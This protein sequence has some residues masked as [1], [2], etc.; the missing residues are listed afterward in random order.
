VIAQLV[1]AGRAPEE[2]TGWHIHETDFHMV[3][4][5]R[6]WAKFMYE[7]QVTLVE[8][9]DCVYQRPGIKHFLFDY[10]PDM[11]YLEVVGPADFGS[12]GVPAVC[13]VSLPAH[14]PEALCG[15]FR[16]QERMA[17]CENPP[18]S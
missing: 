1:R 13:D 8:A 2:G 18:S 4:M 12:V 10:S 5:L 17:L 16:D 11:E 15:D 3:L 7:D 6:G 14:W 9:G